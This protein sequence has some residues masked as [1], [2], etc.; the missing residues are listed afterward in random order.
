MSFTHS[1]TVISVGN[2]LFCW[3]RFLSTSSFHREWSLTTRDCPG[4]RRGQ[5]PTPHWPSCRTVMWKHQHWSKKYFLEEKDS[6]KPLFEVCYKT[7]LSPFSIL[8]LS[9]L[10]IKL[11]RL[12][13]HKV[14]LPNVVRDWSLLCGRGELVGSGFLQTW[15]EAIKIGDNRIVVLM[16]I[17]IPHWGKIGVGRKV[18]SLYSFG[19]LASPEEA[20]AEAVLVSSHLHLSG[21]EPQRPRPSS[22]AEKRCD[23]SCLFLS[24]SLA[25]M[26]TSWSCRG[27]PVDLSTRRFEG[28]F[29]FLAAACIEVLKIHQGWKLKR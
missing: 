19:V 16:K 5:T 6:R 28:F 20:G 22:E 1:P 9:I 11:A 18:G 29:V 13:C 26:W 15:D 3:Q 14:H 4:S 23:S 10:T 12:V 17:V 24:F 2:H 21:S 7:A 27:D 25:D 8:Y